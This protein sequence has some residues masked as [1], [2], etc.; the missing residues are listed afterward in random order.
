MSFDKPGFRVAQNALA[1][2][3][4]LNE[5]PDFTPGYFIADRAYL[6]GAIAHEFQ[7]PM[8]QRGWKLVGD[9][10][11]AEA[12]TGIQNA[13][14]GAVMIDGTWFHAG[15]LAH[16]KLANA[17]QDFMSGKITEDELDQRIATRAA[18]KLKRKSTVDSGIRY[19]C[20][21]KGDYPDIFCPFCSTA[22]DQRVTPKADRF[23]ITEDD[24]ALVKQR[25][26]ID[27]SEMCAKQ[28][29]LFTFEDHGKFA[30]ELLWR[31]EEWKAVFRPARST[32]EQINENL[33]SARGIGIG[34]T[35]ARLMR[36]WA[37]QMMMVCVGVVALNYRLVTNWIAG[38]SEKV[39][40]LE[41]VRAT[42][43]QSHRPKG[44]EV[45]PIGLPSP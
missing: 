27:A 13:K 22:T 33:K 14:N 37:K 16:P 9:Q 31:S 45:D 7:I 23:L 20:P 19:S 5:N 12:S 38:N 18:L 11:N 40:Q 24:M 2:L 41:K 29:R 8:M 17:T 25:Y 30:Q 1:S 32:I 39:T 42:A 3:S 43:E 34:D 10:R 6:P 28:S 26:G 21:G 4:H 35:I 36:G 15:I 44:V